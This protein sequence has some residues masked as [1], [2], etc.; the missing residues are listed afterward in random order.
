MARKP[1]LEAKDLE[2]LGASTLAALL[3]EISDGDDAVKRRLRVALAGARSPAAAAREIRKRLSTIARS[4]S[5]VEWQNVK[6]LAAD[7]DA[8]RRA[9]VETVARADASEALDLMWTFT[10]LSRSVFDRCEHDVAVAKVFRA[11]VQDLGR[12]AE[13]E[14]GDPEKL[15]DRVFSALCENRYDQFDGLVAALGSALGEDGLAHLEKRMIAWSLE[16][17][18]RPPEQERKVIGWF[19]GG[20]MYEDEI[21]DR[22]RAL[23]V[24]VA[25]REI[26]DARGDVDAFIRQFSEE[27]RKAPVVASQIAR[28]LL[29]AGRA[30]EALQAIERAHSPRQSLLDFEL[31]DLR[32]EALESLGK[33]DDAQN[34][35]RS[36]FERGL[37]A[38]H[39]KEFLGR[40][41]EFDD[42]EAEERALD[43]AERHRNLHLALAFLASWPA[44]E[45]AARLVLARLNDIDGNRYEEL[46]PAA[47][48]LAARFPL[49]ATLLLRTMIDFALDNGRSSRYRHAARH[50]DDCAALATRIPE[51][52][53]FG[54]HDD[55]TERLR[56]HHGRKSSFW[57]LVVE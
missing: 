56:A 38:R 18:R 51:F 37:S 25:L 14:K 50:M 13:A 36:C 16:P 44:L 12:L 33:N 32:V 21:A 8:Q 29:D 43:L 34:A 52:G 20:P 22:S 53:A 2:A 39:L 41:P 46:A 28:R 24:R 57:S 54:T 31:D 17:I 10:E 5:F 48:A 23:L 49:E 4:R 9:I 47:E 1:S 35:R 6:G 11:A 55:F 27:M 3:I 19:S 7:L 30:E 26:A 40:L 45:R 15:A 42:I